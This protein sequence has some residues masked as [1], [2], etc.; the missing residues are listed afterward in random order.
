MQINM[1]YYEQCLSKDNNGRVIGEQWRIEPYFPRI[2]IPFKTAHA[3][4]QMHYNRII[5][6]KP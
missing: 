4:L 2:G 6:T 3:D 5:E 1:I